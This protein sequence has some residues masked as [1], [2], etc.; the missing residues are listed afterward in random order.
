M[1]SPFVGFN[2]AILKIPDGEGVLSV[3]PETGN[4]EQQNSF[5]TYQAILMLKRLPFLIRNDGVDN[6]T[7]DVRG[8]LV[9]PMV[10][11]P[12]F[13]LPAKVQCDFIDIDNRLTS[14][15]LELN[16][17][18]DPFKV[19]TIAGQR[20]EGTFTVEGRGNEMVI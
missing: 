15:I 12:G 4:Y 1:T 9:E 10:F 20:L 13:C 19:G 6:T 5:I 8:Y 18:P 17:I 14:G 3:N 16:I 7:I 11:P 2:N